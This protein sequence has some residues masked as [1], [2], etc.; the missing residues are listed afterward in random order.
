M[1]LM[2][3]SK[4]ALLGIGGVLVLGGVITA[5][6]LVVLNNRTALTCKLTSD[7]TAMG[8]KVDSVYAVYGS[9]DAVNKVTV[10]HAVQSDSEETRNTLIDDYKSQFDYNNKRYGGYE[11]NV[12][13]LNGNEIV[14]SGSIDYSKMDMEKFKTDNVAMEDF[15]N[16]NGKLGLDGAK[17]LYESSGATCNE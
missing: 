17:R 12:S 6:V 1:V 7:Q 11:Y 16:E 8:Y 4:Y 9:Q 10:R 3:K 13:G 15:L 5:I 14:F 2:K